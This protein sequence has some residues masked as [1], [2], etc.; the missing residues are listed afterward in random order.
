MKKYIWY[1]DL[2]NSIDRTETSE[3]EVEGFQEV[4]GPVHLRSEDPRAATWLGVVDRPEAFLPKHPYIIEYRFQ[5][6]VARLLHIDPNDLETVQDRGCVGNFVA[7]EG[8]LVCEYGDSV[9]QCSEE[10]VSAYRAG[11]YEIQKEGIRLL[12]LQEI[13]LPSHIRIEKGVA[14]LSNETDRTSIEIVRFYP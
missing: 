12:P 3:V 4:N 14:C 6:E 9:F 13:K 2:L 7:R 8:M 5:K 1:C 11:T 10:L